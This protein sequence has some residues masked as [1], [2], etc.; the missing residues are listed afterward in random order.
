MAAVN[1]EAC[2]GECRRKTFQLEP[3]ALVSGLGCLGGC[4]G[5]LAGGLAALGLP[6]DSTEPR[7][8]FSV[9]RDLL[10]RSRLQDAAAGQLMSAPR[11]KRA[12]IYPRAERMVLPPTE[13]KRSKPAAQEMLPQRSLARQEP[14]QAMCRA[15][16]AAGYPHF[17][18]VQGSDRRGQ[19]AA[20]S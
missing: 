18:H 10:L 14:A 17:V 13:Q 3:K 19:G 15:F 8:R 7:S 1:R 4:L 11:Q 16:E 5:A 20:T 6:E 2:G 12:S 9:L